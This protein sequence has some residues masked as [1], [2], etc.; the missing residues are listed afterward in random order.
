MKGGHRFWF[1]MGEETEW[2][3]TLGTN[4]KKGGMNDKE[5]EK[6]VLTNLERLCSDVVDNV[7]GHRVILKVD[8]GPGRMNI[9]LLVPWGSTKHNCH[10]TGDRSII[11]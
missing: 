2:P 11:W 6:Y 9:K 3:C 5:F 1:G 7:A 8:S 10:H 4:E